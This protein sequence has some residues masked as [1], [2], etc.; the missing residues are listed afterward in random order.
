LFNVAFN[1]AEKVVGAPPDGFG[2]LMISAVRGNGAA[3][4]DVN[5][6][7]TSSKQKIMK[8]HAA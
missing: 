3:A 2:S 1:V 6:A 7:V 4:V 5:V 8:L